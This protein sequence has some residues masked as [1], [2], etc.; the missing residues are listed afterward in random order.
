M[1]FRVAELEAELNHNQREYGPR[2]TAPSVRSPITHTSH[3][4]TC[5]TGS[6]DVLQESR[7]FGTPHA[8]SR[9][10]A[11]KNRVF[12]QSHWMNGFVMFKDVIE[13]LDP[14]LRSGKTT[15][16]ADVHRSKVLARKI[17]M[18]R[19]PIWPLA[20]TNDLPPRDLCDILVDRYFC[21]SETLYRVLHIPTFKR[22]YDAIWQ[23]EKLPSISFM[24]LLKL[25]LAI[26]AVTYDENCSLRP[27][28]T[29]WIFEAQTWL[30][31]PV[32][33]SKLGLQYI[34][35]SILLLLAREFVDVGGELIWIQAGALLRA[36]IYIG[37]HKDPSQLPRMTFFEIEM[38]RR[39]WNT[40]LEVN[41]QAS[42]MSGGPCTISMDDFNTEPPGNFDDDQLQ[43]QSSNRSHGGTYTDMSLVLALRTTYTARLTVIRFLNDIATNGTYE[44]TLRIDTTLRVAYKLMRNTLQPY[45]NASTA[46]SH[47]QPSAFALSSLDFIIHRFITSLHVP[48]FHASLHEAVYAYSRK[49][50]VD[51]S[52]KIWNLAKSPPTSP[53]FS[54]SPTNTTESDLT[55]FCRCGAGLFRASVFHASSFLAVE[56]RAQLED[57]DTAV[58]RPDLVG[59]CNEAADW[60]L[61]S[62]EAGETGIKGFILLRIIK[63]QIDCVKQ[64]VSR[65]GMPAILVKAA[66]DAAK[67]CLPVLESLAGEN[68]G[69][70][71]GGGGGERG[72]VGDDFDLS[73]SADF[74]QDWDVLMSDVFNVGS[75]GDFSAFF[76]GL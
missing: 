56:L 34:Q 69:S 30:S 25:V 57:E 6:I 12:G 28:A 67:Y 19:T 35:T 62:V 43:N 58:P 10:I 53:P 29:S 49:S 11:H 8:I 63:A 3:V 51:S 37:L 65:N 46:S 73:I 41:L 14:G 71:D 18:Q 22:D 16:L 75:G 9:G 2:S 5:L 52:F 54:S 33:K 45:S 39:L 44:E 47:H 66:E 64:R 76:D 26:G 17:K 42:L 36:A 21:T 50:V 31:S 20:P 32:F 59:I 70:A 68:N 27:Q 7:E 55:R 15:L 24:V 61:R 60:V 40:I 72:A 38:R 1:K 13:L 23:G 48:F 74:L 4:A